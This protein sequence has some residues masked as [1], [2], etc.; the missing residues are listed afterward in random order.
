MEWGQI[1]RKGDMVMVQPW[2]PRNCIEALISRNMSGLGEIL[3][4]GGILSV[5]LW[6]PLSSDFNMSEVGA[7][8]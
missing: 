4:K 1:F 7:D 3:R 5:P 8:S 2:L 6:L